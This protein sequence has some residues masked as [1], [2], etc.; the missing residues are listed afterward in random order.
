MKNSFIEIHAD[1][2]DKRGLSGDADEIRFFND[3]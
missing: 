1:N 2:P 3:A